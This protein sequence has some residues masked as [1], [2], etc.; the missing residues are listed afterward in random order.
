MKYINRTLKDK[1]NP[2]T[3]I[4]NKILRES[5]LSPNAYRIL[6][7]MLSFPDEWSHNYHNIKKELGFSKSTIS[8]AIEELENKDY[9][10]TEK[11]IVNSKTKWFHI[12][13]FEGKDA[14]RNP[15]F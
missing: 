14:P 6:T 5:N 13:V 3:R 9:V 11:L 8:R 2:F 7:Y 12:F 1:D 15:Q 10:R 4:D